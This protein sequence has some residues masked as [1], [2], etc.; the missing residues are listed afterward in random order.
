MQPARF[1]PGKHDPVIRAPEELL[2]SDELRIQ[3]P[4]S[5]AGRP[6]LMANAARGVSD[7]DRPRTSRTSFEKERRPTGGKSDEGDARPIRRPLWIRVA[8][9]A[10]RQPDDGLGGHVV[11]ADETVIAAL[12]HER[13]LGPVGRPSE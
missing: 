5:F 9:H 2:S 3:T 7:P 8:V 1:L 13:E 6:E 12:T 10:R 11:H 4:R